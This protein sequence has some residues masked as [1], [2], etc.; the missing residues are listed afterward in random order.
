MLSSPCTSGTK[1]TL[2]SSTSF[3]GEQQARESSRERVEADIA[4][5][6]H[7]RVN[8]RFHTEYDIAIT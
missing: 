5:C 8:L 6:F 2:L 4:L 7:L 1:T 3:Q